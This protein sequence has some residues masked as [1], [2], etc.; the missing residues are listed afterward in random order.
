[1]TIRDRVVATVKNWCGF[2]GF[3]TGTSLAVLWGQSSQAASIPFKPQA[4]SD[5]ISKLHTEFNPPKPDARDLSSWNPDSFA[6]GGTIDTVD[7]LVS[8]VMFAP[9]PAPVRAFIGGF[10]HDGAKSEMVN[11]IADEVVRRLRPP[12]AGLKDR[13][14]KRGGGKPRRKAGGGRKAGGK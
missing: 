2:G 1:M 5:L 13:P 6:P 4:V 3:S 9:V 8:A 14:E 11:A 12:K 7:D 10:A